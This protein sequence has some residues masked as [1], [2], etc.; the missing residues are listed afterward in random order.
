MIF[1]SNAVTTTQLATVI[2]DEFIQWFRLRISILNHPQHMLEQDNLT[3]HV[4]RIIFIIYLGRIAWPIHKL[5]KKR[6][7]NNFRVN[8]VSPPC[9]SHKHRAKVL[10]RLII[11]HNRSDTGAVVL[12]VV[13]V[14]GEGVP[15]LEHWFKLC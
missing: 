14:I 11:I 5:L 6:M 3:S 13:V 15:F 12:V 4:N 10:C 2:I 7:T 8:K 9:L 1:C